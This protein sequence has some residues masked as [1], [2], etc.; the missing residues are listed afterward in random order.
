MAEPTRL[1]RWRAA[2]TSRGWLPRAWT[3]SRSLWPPGSCARSPS[4]MQTW[5]VRSARRRRNDAEAV[6][7]LDG[8]PRRLLRGRDAV[9]DRLAQRRRRVQRLRD[10]AAGRKQRPVDVRTAIAHEKL[11]TTPRNPRPY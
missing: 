1:P 8:D 2:T 7:L 6:V 5:P 10:Q 9:G 3:W 11:T 4:S